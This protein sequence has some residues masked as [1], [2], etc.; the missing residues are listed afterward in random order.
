MSGIQEMSFHVS[1]YFHVTITSPSG[2]AE[3]WDP[4]S[5]TALSIQSGS[6]VPPLEK[7][8]GT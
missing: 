4:L 1:T 7:R 5:Q 6:V 2:V 8:L 3:S